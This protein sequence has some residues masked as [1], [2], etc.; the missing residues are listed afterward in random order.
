MMYITYEERFRP[1]MGFLNF[2]ST[3]YTAT[4]AV[5]IV[6][7]PLWG[8]LISNHF[9]RLCSVYRLPVSVPL[10]GFLISNAENATL[11]K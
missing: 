2:K 6:S 9:L 1:L 8:F 3:C 5:N 7:V 4:D 11:A 10:W